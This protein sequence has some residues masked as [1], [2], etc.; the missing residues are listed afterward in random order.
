MHE[1]LRQSVSYQSLDS[2]MMSNLTRI[3]K[4]LWQNYENLFLLIV[5]VNRGKGQVISKCIFGIFNSPKKRTK[6]IVFTT[7]LPHVE[8]FSFDFW[9]N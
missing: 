9:E 3:A 7:M 2:P 1:F 6:K 8:L 4:H 5:R